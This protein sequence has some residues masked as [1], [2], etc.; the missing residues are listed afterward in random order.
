MNS[1]DFV[2]ISYLS[3]M[4][5]VSRR[6]IRYDLD[7]I[8]LFLK[9]NNLPL[10]IRKP[11]AGIKY[12][13][14]FEAKV[15]A[16]ELSDTAEDK[17]HILSK[18]ER[19]R[20]IISEVIR[21]KDFTTIDAIAEKLDVSRSTVINDLAGV[22][23]WLERYGVR[24]VSSPK[25]GLAV[26]SEE[27]QL[28]KAAVDLLLE[29]MTTEVNQ[30]YM[31]LQQDGKYSIPMDKQIKIL[32]N[33]IDMPF[34]EKCIEKLEEK[35]CTIISDESYSNLAIHMAI[36][37]KRIQLGRKIIMPEEEL[38]ALKAT[39]EFTA[40]FEIAGDMEGHFN[41][42]I[43]P[44]EV[45]YIAVHLL[46]SS[47]SREKTDE[48]EEWLEL[49]LITG[50]LV[51]ELSSRINFDLTKDKQLFNGLK[52]H[53][54]PAIY[55]LRHG[56]K[57]KNPILNQIKKD[58]S[59]LF[60]TVKSCM[61]VAE[62]YI[63]KAFE[64]DEIG[65]FTIHFGAAIERLRHANTL[66]TRVLVIC[67][68]GLGTAK[69]LSSRLKAVFDVEIAGT[70]SH[71][72]AGNIL[73]KKY[74][75]LV[76][77]TLPYEYD[78][79]KTIR[80][81]PLL[82]EEDICVLSKYIKYA[83]GRDGTINR[84]IDIINANCKIL[85][86]E[87]LIDDLSEFLNI[88]NNETFGEGV[89]PMLKEIIGENNIKLN[90]EVD[91]WEDAV[92]AGGELLVKNGYVKLEYIDAMIKA[93]KEIGP[94][95]VI[96]PGIAMPHARPESGA[97][98]IGLS[99]VTLKKPINFGNRENDPVRIVISLC[100][101]D[102]L[103]HLKALSELVQLLRDEKFITTVLNSKDNKEIMEYINSNNTACE[104]EC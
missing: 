11:N 103:T 5:N 97:I 64:D 74:V 54:R 48:R 79:I 68:T 58:Y 90:I 72:Q 70:A 95:I 21:Q 40:A 33:D 86:Y 2:E 37:V 84:L 38:K 4:F 101:V 35:L 23:K 12:P 27:N 53:L 39:N 93:V 102:H 10:L 42:H 92:K 29:T 15:K 14:V 94:Y 104:N 24:L 3:I 51:K 17:Y 78:G 9:E 83:K 31:G 8:D 36:A 60:E 26:E 55:R 91:T 88:A 66:R 56:L 18:D 65:Y 30:S 99:L 77:S 41:I 73:N 98:K 46:G 49:Q 81:N 63:G 100:A 59:E 19:R 20:I 47:I 57:S 1:N 13:G 34:I 7:N 6:T 43:P 96:A 32:F 75:D 71:H 16:F 87:K 67:G 50:K 76:V 85:N 80:V 62:E 52:E 28:R 22:R 25:R 61:K 44:D 45:G 82:N 89:Q 69:L